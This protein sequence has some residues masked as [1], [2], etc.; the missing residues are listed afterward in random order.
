MAGIWLSAMDPH[1]PPKYWLELN[2][3]LVKDDEGVGI[4]HE[5]VGIYVVC[6]KGKR[7]GQSFGVSFRL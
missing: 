4:T 5:L 2:G 1:L 3:E 7:G 6:G